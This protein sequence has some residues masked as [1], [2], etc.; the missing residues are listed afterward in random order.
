MKKIFAV[1]INFNNEKIT[2]DWLRSMEKIEHQGFDF[3]L[4]IIDNAS[5]KKFTAPKNARKNVHVI[6]S[7]ENTG[8]SGGNNI[9]IK[10]A[11][12]HGADYVLIINNDTIAD[13]HLVKNLLEV[14]E[15]D[16]KIGITTPKIYFEK[17]RE[18]HKDWYTKNDLG[19][20]IW[21]AGGHIDWD[22]IKSVHRG[23]NEVD[24]GQFDNCEKTDFASGCCILIK[25]EVFQKVGLF[26]DRCFMYFEDAIFCES[27]KKSGYELW[28][29]PSAK[30]WHLNAASSGGSGNDLQ[31]Y[32]ITRNQM[33]F[34]FLFAPLRSKIALILQ[35]A[36]FLFNGRTMQK[37]GILDFYLRRFGK[38]T[39]FQ[40]KN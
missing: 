5:I 28:Y 8:F 21:F 18:F 16:D 38:G 19:K 30:L 29:V 14:L 24:H 9:G 39:Y 13:P 32:F 36:R 23:V 37:K 26:D 17:G 31:D 34:G 2:M 33:L 10:Y 25:K 35:S 15:S 4:V 1:T 12:E 3:E 20:V 27:A 22:N 40:N 11:L 6:E 7:Q